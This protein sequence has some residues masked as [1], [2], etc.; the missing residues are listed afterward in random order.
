M[1]LTKTSL[2]NGIW[3]GSLTQTSESPKLVVTHQGEPVGGLKVTPDGANTWRI[4][5]AIPSDLISDGIQSFLISNGDGQ[6][7]YSIDIL[8]GDA[9]DED[10]R[11]ELNLLRGELDVL[12]KAFRQHCQDS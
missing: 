6:T 7:V 9:L 11:A 12:K 4:S 10:I 5:F 8:A 2:T 3:E 1:Q